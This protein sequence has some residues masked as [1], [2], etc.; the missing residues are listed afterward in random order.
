MLLDKL[1]QRALA[2]SSL[3]LT[4]EA[5]TFSARLI[6][7]VGKLATAPSKRWSSGVLE[8]SGAAS[9]GHNISLED[10]FN[11]TDCQWFAEIEIGTPAQYV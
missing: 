1:L 10:W 7:R 5:L 6:P 2:V 9:A 3:A 8:R 4:V 11:R